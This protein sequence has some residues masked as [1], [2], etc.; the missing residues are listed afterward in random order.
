[1]IIQPMPTFLKDIKVLHKK[2][3][4]L[5][6]D[7]ATF[8]ESLQNDPQQGESLG[9]NCYKVRFDIKSKKAGKRDNSR[10]ITCVKIERD[11]IY[12]LAAYDKAEKATIKG[13]AFDVLLKQI[14]EK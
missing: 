12:L 9:R 8:A 11:T 7:L 5:A 6:D 14:P 10:V 13:K 3:P 1:M 4:S 2:Y